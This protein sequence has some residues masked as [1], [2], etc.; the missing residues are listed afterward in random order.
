MESKL[1]AS[2]KL[3]PLLVTDNWAV[4]AVV[5]VQTGRKRWWTEFAGPTL[6]VWKPTSMEDKDGFCRSVMSKIDSRMDVMADMS[7]ESI[8]ELLPQAAQATSFNEA[9]GQKWVVKSWKPFEAARASRGEL[10]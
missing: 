4:Q 2:E 7:M 6:K 1:H 9:G 8:S 3:G 5:Q 10:L